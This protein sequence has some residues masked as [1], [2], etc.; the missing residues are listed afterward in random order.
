MPRGDLFKQ[1][2]RRRSP[3]RTLRLAGSPLSPILKKDNVAHPRKRSFSMANV[4]SQAEVIRA[5]L[6]VIHTLNVRGNEIFNLTTVDSPVQGC[7]FRPKEI[8]AAYVSMSEGGLI[9]ATNQPQFLKLTD[10]GF[11]AIHP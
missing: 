11:A 8:R 7:G 9:E 6:D 10:A 1:F 5:I 3:H 2:S 4:P